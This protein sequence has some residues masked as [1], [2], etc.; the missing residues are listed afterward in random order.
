MEEMHRTRSNPDKRYRGIS[1]PHKIPWENV[2]YIENEWAEDMVLSS[3][4]GFY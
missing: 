2:D 1:S 3:T 4:D